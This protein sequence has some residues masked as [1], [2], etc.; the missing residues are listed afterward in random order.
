MAEMGI[1]RL[2]D[3]LVKAK[4]QR[5]ELTNSWEYYQ[6][7]KREGGHRGHTLFRDLFEKTNLGKGGGGTL[8]VFVQGTEVR[9]AQ[10]SNGG[11]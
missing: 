2:G 11:N 3:K 1:C 7:K 9:M 4:T 8:D 6:R 10:R 5:V